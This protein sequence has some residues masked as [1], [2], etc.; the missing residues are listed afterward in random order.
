[1]NRDGLTSDSHRVLEITKLIIG[2]V[3]SRFAGFESEKDWVNAD[4]QAALELHDAISWRLYKQE[5]KQWRMVGGVGLGGTTPLAELLSLSQ[6]Q[7]LEHE[8][9]FWSYFEPLQEKVSEGT[10]LFS[11]WQLNN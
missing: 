1:M 9:M 7:V 10:C 4:L 8:Q 3:V 11:Q 6:C 2:E 5:S